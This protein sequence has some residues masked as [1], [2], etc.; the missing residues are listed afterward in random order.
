MN[1]IRGKF[2]LDVNVFMEA[3][4]RYYSFDIVPSF[5]DLLVSPVIFKI[6]K[7]SLTTPTEIPQVADTRCGQ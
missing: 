3:H 1:A 4:Q 6:S 5:W 7:L 2:V